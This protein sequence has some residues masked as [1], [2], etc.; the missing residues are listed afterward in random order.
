MDKLKK[1]ASY[2]K[3][4]RKLFLIDLFCVVVMTCIDLVYPMATRRV[5]N[6]LLPDKNFNAIVKVTIALFI[7]FIIRFLCSYF[8]DSWGHIVGVRIEGDMREKVFSHIQKLSVNFYDNN[9]TGH[10]MSRIIN[11][12]RDI[13]ELAHHGPEDILISSIMLIGS[14]ALLFF[15]DWRLTLIVFI[16]LPFMAIFGAVKKKRMTKAFRSQRYAIADINSSL[17]NSISGVRVTK[18]FTGEDFEMEKFKR[19]N[20]KFVKT[21][22]KAY[23]IMAEFT[24][25]ILLFSNMLDVIILL[26][27]GYFVYKDMIKVGDLVAYILYITYFLQPIRK[28]TQFMQQYQDGMTG[29]ERYLE[30]MDV[31]PDVIDSEY[32]IELINPEGE[33]KFKNVYFKYNESERFTLEDIS[34]TV[35]PGKTVALV[36]PSG[37]GKSTI[38]QLIPR[39]YDVN[40]GEISIDGIDIRNISLTSLRENIGY[41]HQ[42]VFLF[43]GTL[44]DNIMYGNR[45]ATESEM[46]GA[47]INANIHEFIMSLPN[48]YDTDIGEK[49]VKLS[50]GQKQ[51]IS[52]ARVFLKNPKIIILDEATSAL[53]NENEIII[54]DSLDRLSA[55]RTTL[56]IA[57]RLSTIKNSDKILVLTDEGIVEEGKHE[58]LLR[59]KGIYYSLFTAQFKRND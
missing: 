25:G 32:S 51:R 9:R 14:F 33:I 48:G 40:C 38:C 26:V 17:E 29:F 30:I 55:G 34:F 3:P 16:L 41:V 8:V 24:S 45:K 46:I 47:A 28:L 35:K 15:I 50:G 59:D 53:D 21:R 57:H 44:R 12:L 7:L 1:F 49:G 2:Y 43:T 54:Q 31:E 10:I 42:D 6:D 4:H 23:K 52:I 19:G 36:G 11:D 58:E 56:V 13:T 22:E 39:F 20:D 37:G 18:A 5:I 27:G